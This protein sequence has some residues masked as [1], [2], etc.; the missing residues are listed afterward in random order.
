MLRIKLRYDDVEAMVQRFAPNV[1]KSGLFLPTKSI[2]PIGTE[3]K[4]ELRL[5]NDRP[6]LVGMGKVKHVKPPD[7]Q[8]PRAAF[9]MAIELTRVSRDGREVII[10]MI[11][12]RRAMGLPDVAIPVPDDIEAAR[13]SEVE[14]QPRAET[15]GIVRDAMAQFASAPVAEQVLAGSPTQTGPIGTVKD[16]TLTAPIVIAKGT[17]SEPVTTA[18]GTETD[19]VPVMREPEV[20][21]P[22]VATERPSA[23]LMTAPRPSRSTAEHKAVAVLAPEPARGKRPRVADLIAKATELSAPLAAAPIPE[24]D[25]QVDVQRALARARVLAGG[26]LDAELSAVREAAAAPIEIGI[27]AASAELARQLGGKPIIKRDRSAGW[28]PPPA[29]EMRHAVEAPA[30]SDPAFAAKTRA[31][32][33]IAPSAVLAEVTSAAVEDGSPGE[34]EE[35]PPLTDEAPLSM[36][37]PSSEPIEEENVLESRPVDRVEPAAL[38]AQPVDDDEPPPLHSEPIPRLPSNLLESEPVARVV[39]DVEPEPIDRDAHLRD[40]YERDASQPGAELAAVMAAQAVAE[41]DDE[42]PMELDEADL[43]PDED[44]EQAAAAEYEQDQQTRVPSGDE[45]SS[46]HAQVARGHDL[47]AST[48]TSGPG[49]DEDA[50]REFDRDLRTRVPSGDDELAADRGG[51]A[52]DEDA[53]REFDRDLRTRVPSDDDDV[54][55]AV[56]APSPMAGMMISDDAD[57]AEF[58]RALDHAGDAADELEVPA[59]RTQIGEAPLPP[60]PVHGYPTTPDALSDSLDQQL[61]DAEAEASSDLALGMQ[62]RQ[63]DAYGRPIVFDDNG[64]PLAG[65]DAN[66]QPVGYDEHGRPLAMLAYDANGNPIQYDEHG[67]PV[68]YD[69]NGQPIYA[70]GAYAEAQPAEHLD[71]EGEEISD[72]E[73]LAEA[74]EQDADLLGAP[75]Y[76]DASFQTPPYEKAEPDEAIAPQDRPSFDFASALDLG[77]EE[78]PLAQQIHERSH[79][80]MRPKRRSSAGDFDAP[81]NSYT[82]AENPGSERYP[83]PASPSLDEALGA[84]F[85]DAE[86]EFDAPHGYNQAPAQPPRPAQANPRRPISEPQFLRGSGNPDDLEDALAALDVDL[87]DISLDP[88]R[89]R[90]TAAPS[91][92]S[93]SDPR[94]LPGLPLHRPSEHSRPIART[95]P[96]P[97]SAADLEDP[98]STQY[99]MRRPKSG[100][101]TVLPKKPIQAPGAPKRAATDDGILIDFDDDE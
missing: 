64:Q 44:E 35:A 51:P 18:K 76:P 2:Q 8:Q 47:D 23:P 57:V 50:A 53:A 41:D 80:P 45:A 72:F 54:R 95:V 61:A 3:V 90:R 99:V 11:E 60:G 88:Q 63:F 79:A 92:R 94:P 89:S 82:F 85:D 96:R 42:E 59:E 98:P 4:F 32:T 66:G 46:L 69:A 55:A 24:L 101:E 39:P 31:E 84:S 19:A 43:E 36:R 9:G 48:E 10:R 26:D 33:E 38:E 75:A 81:S 25:E 91:P 6:V 12:R 78:P 52:I 21:K 30:T 7:P 13:R 93:S 27:E 87:D 97:P 22:A 70:A 74:D 40:G 34:H 17:L 65:Y 58:E 67:N 62:E 49:V 5:A 86:H 16:P 1:G 71:D 15:S 29:V 73:V 14:S 56:R 83:L 77:E 37:A 28:A 20:V 68:S 100:Q